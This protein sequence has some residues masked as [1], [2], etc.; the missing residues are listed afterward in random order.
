MS[1]A[2]SCLESRLLKSVDLLLDGGSLSNK[3]FEH[4]Y[5]DN[6]FSDKEGIKTKLYALAR[7]ISS[8]TEENNNQESKKAEESNKIIDGFSER[9]E[10]YSQYIPNPELEGIMNNQIDSFLEVLE[11]CHEG[12]GHYVQRM[13]A[14]TNSAP[15]IIPPPDGWESRGKN[16]SMEMMST[17][18]GPLLKSMD[19]VRAQ[20]HNTSVYANLVS[21]II[22]SGLE[23]DLPMEDSFDYAEAMAIPEFDLLRGGN[24][25]EGLVSRYR[26]AA[27][28]LAKEHSVDDKHTFLYRALEKAID[29]ELRK[30]VD[31]D[32]DR[33]ID[34]RLNEHKDDD[35]GAL[36]QKLRHDAED[37]ES[38]FYPYMQA[39]RDC[40]CNKNLRRSAIDVFR[41]YA[42]GML[43]LGV[44]NDLKEDAYDHFAILE[45][46]ENEEPDAQFILDDMV[47]L[48]NFHF[49]AL[50][51]SGSF[52]EQGIEDYTRLYS[53][54]KEHG[55]NKDHRISYGELALSLG[56]DKDEEKAEELLGYMAEGQEKGLIAPASM[57]YALLKRNNGEDEN[58]LDNADKLSRI[59]SH[60]RGYLDVHEASARLDNP[61]QAFHWTNIAGS[62]CNDFTIDCAV[63]EGTALVKEKGNVYKKAKDAVDLSRLARSSYGKVN[64]AS[65]RKLSDSLDKSRHLK[66]D[67][68]DTVLAL[69]NALPT[70][71]HAS[72][73]LMYSAATLN[74]LIAGGTDTQGLSRFRHD[75]MEIQKATGHNSPLI[76]KNYVDTVKATASEAY[77]A[78]LSSYTY[79][80][81]TRVFD[82]IKSSNQVKMLYDNMAEGVE[83]DTVRRLIL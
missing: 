83:L 45:M 41:N 46:E 66:Q 73:A 19:H 43:M 75:I 21:S 33:E 27:L 57:M 11:T 23:N 39:V 15:R 47:L 63:R 42:W 29:S 12:R 16:I 76:V 17:M 53:A 2:E 1:E 18:Q 65:V 32:V 55:L 20:M 5:P 62:L 74:V 36:E 22:I 31:H 10:K 3:Y 79:P 70:E 28:A 71:G 48:I 38:L 25:S 67:Y 49:E 6:D 34:R 77:K 69:G 40:A 60:E 54:A 72:D 78:G 30:Y 81:L 35:L 8:A 56:G 61:E 64:I 4:H 9:F 14:L 37:P 44:D 80:E 58:T 52:N 82:V 26:S 7:I 68:L 51:N 59:F 50:L 13:L 24:W